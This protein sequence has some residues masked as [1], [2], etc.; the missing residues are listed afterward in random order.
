MIFSRKNKNTKKIVAIPVLVV[1][2]LGCFK[3]I[4]VT[5][6]D[7]KLILTEDEIFVQG[8]FTPRKMN[9]GRIYMYTKTYTQLGLYVSYMMTA[10][11][12]ED[13]IEKVSVHAKKFFEEKDAKRLF[14][15]DSIIRSLYRDALV[16]PQMETMQ[17]DEGF[18]I[19]D[20]NFFMAEYRA[21]NV[22]YTVRIESE[23]AVSVDRNK[24]L[25]ALKPRLQYLVKMS[26]EDN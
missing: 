3:F 11:S 10:Q 19:D 8:T 15:S 14:T 13:D 7:R 6:E 21:G 17:A 12:N 20:E 25:E 16:D 5:P 2:L 22:V 26:I 24:T 9:N 1:L 18:L 4:E 23:T